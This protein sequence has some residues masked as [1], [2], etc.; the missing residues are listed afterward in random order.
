MG[1]RPDPN[2]IGIFGFI[3]LNFLRLALP[4]TSLTIGA[5]DEPEECRVPRG[6]ALLSDDSD[7]SEAELRADL[8][9]QGVDV[10]AFLSRFSTTVRTSIQRQSGAPRFSA[11][12]NHG[13]ILA[14]FA[15]SFAISLF[16]CAMQRPFIQEE[17][18]GTNGVTSKRIAKQTAIAFWPATSELAKG[19]ITAGQSLSIGVEGQSLESGA[20]TNDVEVLR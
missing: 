14:L 18:S 12:R 20:T 9:A 4:A 13:V 1:I 8:E 5:P 19:R 2:V 17:R 7:L 15:M 6:K 10:N 16:G 3:G 11:G